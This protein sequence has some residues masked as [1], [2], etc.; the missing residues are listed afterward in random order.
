ML[1]LQE[2]WRNVTFLKQ[3][4]HTGQT[5]HDSQNILIRK[6]NGCVNNPENSSATKIGEH[7]PCRY[8]MSTIW[9]FDHIE[10]KHPLY[11]RKDFMKKICTSLRE[12]AKNIIDF[13]KKKNVTVNKRITKIILR[14]KSMLYL[15]KKIL[16]K[17]GK[18]KIIE[19]SE[20][21]VVIQVNI[22][23]QHKVFVNSKFNVPNEIS[24]VLIMVQIMIIILS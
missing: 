8:S 19:K 13:E 2:E 9:G 10:F 12:H 15:R 7:D 17:F 11:L 6:I 18:D 24:V 21:I 3:R 4:K 16:K 1:S 20:I 22:E 5:K 14:P 23:G